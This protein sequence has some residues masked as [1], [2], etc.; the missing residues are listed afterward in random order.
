[1]ERYHSLSLLSSIFNYGDVAYVSGGFGV[2]IHNV[3]EAAVWGVPVIFG[4]NNKH[5]QEAQGLMACG[6]GF[7]IANETDFSKLM[8]N[9]AEDKH[10]LSYCGGKSAEFVNS[11]AGATNAILKEISL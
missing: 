9:F 4:T 11:Q 7:E 3:L 6:G 1:M 2:G 5:F 10:Y 8:T